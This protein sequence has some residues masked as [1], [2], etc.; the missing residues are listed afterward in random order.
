ML[1]VKAASVADLKL[2]RWEGAET[3][4]AVEAKRISQI[5]ALGIGGTAFIVRNV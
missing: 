1:D 3:A 4:T 5:D 2:G